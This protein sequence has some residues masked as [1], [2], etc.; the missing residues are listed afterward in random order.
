MTGKLLGGCRDGSGRSK[1]GYYQGIRCGSSYELAFVI[2]CLD[3]NINIDRCDE[4]FLM[5]N[6]R[7]YFPD[8]VCDNIIVEIKGFVTKDS[9]IAMKERSVESLKRAYKIL[10]ANDLKNVFLYVG[11]KFNLKIHSKNCHQ[12]IKFYDSY[13]PKYEY[14]CTNCD[15]RFC[16]D[17]KLKT[18]IV[19]CSRVCA[20]KYVSNDHV[21]KH[22]TISCKYCTKEFNTI[23]S[24]NQ[25]FCSLSCSAK[26]L[27]SNSIWINDGYK[28]KR[29]KHT[30]N[31]P[32]G[33]KRGRVT[34]YRIKK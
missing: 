21:A 1:S 19:F 11:K 8:F 4:N 23:K 7:K 20:G 25:I 33:W 24:K 9:N 18:K 34:Q 2:Y 31:I 27:N 22:I 29:I 32:N 10:Y 6:G 5:E 14:Q 17:I 30:K 3:H 26:H 16:R 13:K 28:N 15:S 12:L